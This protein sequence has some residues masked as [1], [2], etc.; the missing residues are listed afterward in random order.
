MGEGNQKKIKKINHLQADSKMVWRAVV[1]AGGVWPG[2]DRVTV[3]IGWMC[4]IELVCVYV[5]SDCV[6]GG[7]GG[8]V[9]PVRMCK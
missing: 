8:C 6:V 1:G 5:V 7:V 2:Q 3:V 9:G 4:V